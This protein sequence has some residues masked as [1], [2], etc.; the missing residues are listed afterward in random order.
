MAAI[1]ASSTAKRLA[2]AYVAFKVIAAVV[3]LVLFPVV[4]RLMLRAAESVDPVT[5]VAVYHTAYNVVGVAILLPLIGPFTRGIE[6]IVPE[7]VSTFAGSRIPPRSKPFPPWRSRP[8][9]ARWRVCSMP[10]VRRPMRRPM[11]RPTGPWSAR[12]PQP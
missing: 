1:G 7:P 3:A 12:H 11:R 9:A 2:V 8:S 5:L 6:R 10:C 4:V